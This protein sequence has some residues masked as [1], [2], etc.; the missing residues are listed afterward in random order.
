MFLTMILEWHQPIGESV[1]KIATNLASTY[2]WVTP[3]PLKTRSSSSMLQGPMDGG[4]CTTESVAN[5][6]GDCQITTLHAV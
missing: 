3:P 4:A 6:H 2:P 1:T 5:K